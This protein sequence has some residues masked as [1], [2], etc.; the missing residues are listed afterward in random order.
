M[1]LSDTNLVSELSR[2]EP[3]P[4]V[5]LWAQGVRLVTISVIT[6]EEIYFGLHWRPKPKTLVWFG[7]FLEE[8]C[9]VLPISREVA[10]ASARLRGELAKE[11]RPRS[12]ADMLIAA[13]A[14]V[15]DLT[16]VTRNV[17][18]FEGCPISLYNP[19]T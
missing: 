16:L 1:F 19:F 9:E 8:T 7:S 4:G 10:A 3:N 12:Q 17:R 11:G 13:T 14:L 2:P 18:D 15:H 5:L 6:V